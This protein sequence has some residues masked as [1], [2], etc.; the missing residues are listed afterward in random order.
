M[1][2]AGQKAFEIILKHIDDKKIVLVIAGKGNNGGDGLVIARLLLEKGISVKLALTSHPDNLSRDAKE[3]WKKLKPLKPDVIL[4]E[5]E[6]ALPKLKN[7]LSDSAYVVDAIFGT[8]LNAEIKGRYLKIIK[9][10]NNSSR[11]VFAVDIPSGLSAD[12]GRPLGIAVKAKV[13]IT[14]GFPKI[15]QVMTP[16]SDYVKSLHV[17]DIGFPKEVIDSVKSKLFLIT[18]DIFR[19]F[20]LQRKSDSHKGDF[21]HVLTIAGSKS[22]IGAGYLTSKAA[23][24][25]G[26]GLVTYALP[27]AAYSRFDSRFAEVMM[28]EVHDK[29]S[30]RFG[31]DSVEDIK[32]LIKGKD[33]IAFG[34]G[35]ETHKDTEKFTDLIV[36][37]IK[38][39]LVIDADGINNIK[40]HVRVLDKRSADT[41]LTPHPG[42]MSK[43][44][45]KD[46]DSILKNK[47][48]V[49]R[50]FAYSH[51]V[52]LVL[53]GY[54]TVIATPNGEVFINPTGNPGMATAG[55]G[56]VLTGMIAGFVGMKIPFKEAIL[57]AVYIH[58]LAGDMASSRTGEISL[59]ASDIIE[60]IPNAINLIKQT[61]K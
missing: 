25:S 19:D 48:S 24:R 22:K 32:K 10:I 21:G 61:Q 59:I 30:G 2:N 60:N 47:L 31:P 52:F 36:Q 20:F 55:S 51:K 58:G 46:K 45:N 34:P 15:G 3:N 8:G 43:L 27:S 39:P 16:G 44:V 9:L 33:V 4:V 50:E 5:D 28:A 56:D 53:K 26:A 57:A 17:V 1:E 11:P 42:E 29:K 41:V 14:F 7:M 13:T 12:S 54:R 18:P 38:L 23:L 49:A 40:D 37:K 6:E 35:I